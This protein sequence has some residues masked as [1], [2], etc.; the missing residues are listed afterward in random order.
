MTETLLTLNW[1]SAVGAVVLLLISVVLLWAYGTRHTPL[2][3]L[4]RK[5]GLVATSGVAVASL[6]MSLVYS[7]YFGVIPCGLCW[8]ERACIYPLA[9]ILTLASM[10]R[11]HNV[12]P[13]GLV[14]SGVGAVISL[15]HHYLQMGGGS[16]LPCPA[17]GVSDCAKR[18]IF[19]FG[20]VTFPLIAFSVCIFI[21]ATLLSGRRSAP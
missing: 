7:E 12:A 17:S 4:A 20:F 11:D 9:L 15:Y 8:L 3:T 18:I 13:Y 10:K 16:V 19:E 2:L 5:Y 6:L 14:L 21:F 1:L